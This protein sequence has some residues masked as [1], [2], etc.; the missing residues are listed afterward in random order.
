MM[1]ED[2][3]FPFMSS[4]IISNHASTVITVKFNDNEIRYIPKTFTIRHS[5]G[6]GNIQVFEFISQDNLFIPCSLADFEN[7]LTVLNTPINELEIE[8]LTSE[9]LAILLDVICMLEL[10]ELIPQY[11]RILNSSVLEKVTGYTAAEYLNRTNI[12]GQY[13]QNLCASFKSITRQLDEIKH[14][15]PTEKHISTLKQINR[16]IKLID[17]RINEEGFNIDKYVNTLKELMYILCIRD[18]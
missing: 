9:N 3:G 8:D 6:V 1:L 5:L 4:K 12:T 11:Y 7:I 10:K 15:K 17:S 14:F 16:V 18:Q 2:Y 13:Y